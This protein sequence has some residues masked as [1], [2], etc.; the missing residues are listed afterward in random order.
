MKITYS[1]NN[2]KEDNSI[3][4]NVFFELEDNETKIKLGCLSFQNNQYDLNYNVDENL[5]TL[6]SDASAGIIEYLYDEALFIY[7]YFDESKEDFDKFLNKMTQDDLQN[8]LEE[9]NDR[10]KKLSAYINNDCDK[11]KEFLKKIGHAMI[12]NL[13][14]LSKIDLNSCETV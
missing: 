8:I 10:T 11:L 9:I 3:Q 5:W 1:T 2:Y 13:P 4:S 12:N 6:Y 7:N 14:N